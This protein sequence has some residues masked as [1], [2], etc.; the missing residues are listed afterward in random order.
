[1]KRLLLAALLVGCPTSGDDDDSA[2]PTVILVDDDDDATDPL[3][4]GTPVTVPGSFL[5]TCAES[6]PNDAPVFE[7][8]TNTAEPPWEDA[9]D[10]GSLAGTGDLLGITGRIDHVVQDSWGGDTDSFRIT[11][12]EEMTPSVTVQWDPLQGD[13]DARLWCE[14]QSAWVDRADGGLA[15]A[16]APEHVDATETIAAGTECYLFVTGYAGPVADYT[17]WFSRP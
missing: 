8:T 9:T 1:M 3:E 10:C 5:A 17:A 13:F 16:S 4:S 2:G 6:E 15:T 7:G 14:G 11:V 12:T